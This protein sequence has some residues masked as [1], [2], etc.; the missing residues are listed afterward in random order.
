[1]LVVI[2]NNGEQ[3]PAIAGLSR[4]PN[5]Q[6][7]NQPRYRLLVSSNYHRFSWYQFFDEFRKIC[8]GFFDGD[9][10]HLISLIACRTIH[11]SV[12]PRALYIGWN[13]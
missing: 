3:T 9:S 6:I 8:L 13:T 4:L 12:P 5:L 1:M 7:S 2:G 11:N 10:I